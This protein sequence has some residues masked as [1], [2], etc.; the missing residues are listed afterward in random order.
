MGDRKQV[1]VIDDDRALLDA[2]TVG[3]KS[4]TV[5]VIS[6]VDPEAGLRQALRHRPS[7]IVL[8]ILMPNLDGIEL[9]KKLRAHDSAYCK[10][11][12]VIILTNLSDEKAVKQAGKLGCHDYVIKSNVSLN[13]V[14][15]LVKSKLSI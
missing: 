8:D 3:L 13:T 5:D 6:A 7:L 10:T 9:L 12:P 15:E 11:V 2:L 1:L 14:A 4:K